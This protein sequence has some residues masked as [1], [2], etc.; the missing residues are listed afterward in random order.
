MSNRRAMNSVI[1]KIV[2]RQQWQDALQ[3]GIFYGSPADLADGYIHFSTAVQLQETAEKHFAGQADLLL[4]L[5][6]TDPISEN[7]RWER[8]R[9]GELFP[10]LY[11][12]LPL[13]AVKKMYEIGNGHDGRHQFPSE[14][15]A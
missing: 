4:L 15:H 12:P 6:K 3:E 9:S 10:H 8:S 13:E 2:T 7:L 14:I 11:A 5:V 1:Y